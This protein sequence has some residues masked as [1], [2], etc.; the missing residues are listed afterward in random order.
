MPLT[1]EELEIQR[2][3]A[4]LQDF[5]AQVRLQVRFSPEEFAAGECKMSLYK[6]FLDEIV[7]LSDFAILAYPEHYQVLPVI[8]NQGYDAIVFN[9]QGQE[10]EKIEIANPINGEYE[11]KVA[12]NIIDHGYGGVCI[13][14][15]GGDM[16][17][18]IPIIE[19]IIAKKSLKDYSDAVVVFNVAGYPPFEGYEERYNDQIKRIKNTLK[20]KS[21]R[22]KKVC[23]LLP[24]D[25]LKYIEI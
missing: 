16:E 7:P 19:R 14:E 22:A 8:G 17:E 12:R 3:P 4:Q 20:S 25:R 13:G 1:K 24:E 23:L 21:F 15:V 5:I 18:L 10:V 2:T 11:A 6:E 9:Q